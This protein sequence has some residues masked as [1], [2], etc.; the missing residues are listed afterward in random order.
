MAKTAKAS[1][2]KAARDVL[3]V[4]SKIREYIKSKDCN[5]ASD[6]VGALSERVYSLLDD[7]INRTNA[8]GRKT[9]SAKDL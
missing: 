8:N 5:T 9:V 4:G 7:A 6:T 2:S 1:Q 3:V